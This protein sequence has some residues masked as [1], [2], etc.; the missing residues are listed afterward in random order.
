MPVF[1]FRKHVFEG[2][3]NNKTGRQRSPCQKKTF[4]A[5]S[6]AMHKHW[7]HI[8]G[9][10]WRTLSE[11]TLERGAAAWQWF[12]HYGDKL[13]GADVS[14]QDGYFSKFGIPHEVSRYNSE[15]ATEYEKQQK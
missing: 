11:E 9:K 8:M 1:D 15:D 12:V 6:N 14:F 4:S 2:M 10:T 13:Q 3:G 5:Q 7:H